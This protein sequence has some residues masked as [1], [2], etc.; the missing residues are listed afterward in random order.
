[1]A[2][3]VWMD[4][5]YSL[6]N[7]SKSKSKS[8][9]HKPSRVLFSDESKIGHIVDVTD[10]VTLCFAL[11]NRGVRSTSKVSKTLR[12]STKATSYLKVCN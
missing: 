3:F 8:K 5:K 11:S 10:E 1:M 7:Y 9:R 2:R 4:Y 12:S 6:T